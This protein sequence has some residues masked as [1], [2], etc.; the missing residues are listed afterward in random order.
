[1]TCYFHRNHDQSFYFLR[2]KKLNRATILGIFITMSGLLERVRTVRTGDSP[3]V[4]KPSRNKQRSQRY[5]RSECTFNEGIM[6]ESKTGYIG[7]QKHGKEF[8]IE[9]A[10]SFELKTWRKW[11][12]D[13]LHGLEIIK[14]YVKGTLVQHSHIPWQ[15]GKIHGKAET[16]DYVVRDGETLCTAMHRYYENGQF[17]RGEEVTVGAR[18]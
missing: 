8:R 14:Y 6:T 4:T 12:Y 16:I 11:K 13:Q 7:K 17:I 2:P 1:M 10:A 15:D 18:I 9:S 3:K 5:Q